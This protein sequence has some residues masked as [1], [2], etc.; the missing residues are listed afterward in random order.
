MASRVKK[1]LQKIRLLFGKTD[2]TPIDIYIQ[3]NKSKAYSKKY[4]S[5]IKKQTTQNNKRRIQ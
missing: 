3:H 4:K 2:K 5:A 1:K